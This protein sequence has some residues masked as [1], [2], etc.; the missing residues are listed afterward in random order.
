MAYAMTVR[1]VLQEGMCFDA[2]TGSGHHL[3][4]DA[5]VHNG[6]ENRGPQPMEMLL[7]ALATCA[8]MDVL[9]ILRKKRQQITGYEVYVHGDRTEE[10]PR[11][12]VEITVEHIFT[13][14][15]IQPQAVER[16]IELTEEKYCGA[17]A[18]LGKTA[19]LIHTF[20]VLEEQEK[21]TPT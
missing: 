2:E 16:A 7:V 5:A 13:G 14:H 11:V 3:L 15:A 19:R 10:Y 8:G 6:G 21:A 17:S 4:L 12:F 20:R 9:S 18:M 1:A